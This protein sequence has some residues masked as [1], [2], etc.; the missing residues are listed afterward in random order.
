MP[1]R[2]S[3]IGAGLMAGLGATAGVDAA[4]QSQ[5][6]SLKDIVSELSQLRRELVTTRAQSQPGA[7]I[8]ETIRSTSGRF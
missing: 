8:V 7:G 6:Q 1:D 5:E 2:R 4:P 3:L